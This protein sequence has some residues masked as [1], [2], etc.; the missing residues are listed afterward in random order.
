MPYAQLVL[1]QAVIEGTDPAVID[2]IFDGFVRGFSTNALALHNKPTATAVQQRRALD[3]VRRPTFDKA[4]F[5][6]V[7]GKARGLA[8]TYEM[9]A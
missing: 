8:G 2:Q 6:R 1:E 5:E 9:K 4:R 3:L 7:L